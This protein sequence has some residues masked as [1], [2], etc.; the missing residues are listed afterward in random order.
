MSEQIQRGRGQPGTWEPVVLFTFQYEPRPFLSA[1]VWCPLCHQPLCLR[2]H[3]I[4]NDGSV[5]PSVV[6][7]AHPRFAG[8]PWHPTVTL[9]GWDPSYPLPKEEECQRC[10]KRAFVF[11]GWG[12]WSGGTGLICVECQPL[13]HSEA[14]ERIAAARKDPS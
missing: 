4:A 14:R 13:A 1:V 3:D 7:P 12:T 8:C 10:H 5:Y 6:H 9:I 2:N 11:S